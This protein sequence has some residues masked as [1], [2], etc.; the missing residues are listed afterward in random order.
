MDMNEMMA[1]AK[2]AAAIIQNPALDTYI[3]THLGPPDHERM[4][5]LF[6][7]ES[8]NRPLEI[9]EQIIGELPIGGRKV[10]GSYHIV[11]HYGEETS[12]RWTDPTGT[13]RTVSGN[14][15]FSCLTENETE[16]FSGEIIV[17]KESL[18]DKTLTVVASV[19]EYQ[20]VPIEE[21]IMQSDYCFLTMLAIKLLSISERQIIQKYMMPYMSDRMGILVTGCNHLV[22]NGF[23]D[24]Q[25]YMKKYSK[26]KFPVFYLPEKDL[27]ELR[28]M[29]NTLT[30]EKTRYAE[31]CDN[32]YK[33]LYANYIVQMIDG[34]A[35]ALT[36]DN[37]DI[38]K[39][40]L[41]VNSITDRFSARGAR[42]MRNVRLEHLNTLDEECTQTLIAFRNAM[43]A[44]LAEEI[45]KFD[46]MDKLLT[47]IP[48]YIE[49]MWNRQLDELYG[50][51]VQKL[52][53]IQPQLEAYIAKDVALLLEESVSPDVTKVI[54]DITNEYNIRKLGLSSDA[55]KIKSK[56][57][58]VNLLCGGA[59]VVGA[60]MVI[61]SLPITGFITIASSGCVYK[62]KKRAYVSE[63]KR[64]LILAANENNDQIYLDAVEEIRGVFQKN[65]EALR[66][67]IKACYDRV[68]QDILSA[69][70]D[71]R[72]SKDSNN[73]KM[74][75]LQSI[76]LQITA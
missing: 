40:I 10:K 16:L 68:E 75:A 63:S 24:V 66:E 57:E 14:T 51:M 73:Q 62:T 36:L 67:G 18:R 58:N 22:E 41:S 54:I 52:E 76:K 34:Y 43:K 56:K 7:G 1:L 11:I 5:I 20:D 6:L 35:N 3:A 46:D 71:K 65:A 27:E 25:T 4:N 12:Y 48:S 60:A 72:H 33:K 21:L 42:A 2:N 50:Y 49:D 70:E 15:F 13:E 29:F 37:A 23:E 31:D 61:L 64:E 38:E 55:L 8:H 44:K 45:E 26:G 32:C 28:S 9:V 39:L 59:A 53:G 69:L 19:K 30:T 74:K 47:L 17:P